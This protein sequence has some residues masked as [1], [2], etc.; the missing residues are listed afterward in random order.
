MDGDPEAQE[1]YA[2]TFTDSIVELNDVILN[3]SLS[4]VGLSEAEK[5]E[6]L[7]D[8]QNSVDDIGGSLTKYTSSNYTSQKTGMI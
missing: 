3:S 7:T 4:W 2:K 1:D 6:L 8:L 5:R